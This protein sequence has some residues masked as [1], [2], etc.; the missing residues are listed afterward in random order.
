MYIFKSS[1]RQMNTSVDDLWNASS[2]KWSSKSWPM[3]CS[4]GN[5]PKGAKP[6]STIRK[7]NSNIISHRCLKLVAKAYSHI[8]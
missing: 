4:L 6:Q 7:S 5:S 3:N 1:R 2:R 8:V